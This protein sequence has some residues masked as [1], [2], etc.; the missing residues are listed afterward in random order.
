MKK[1]FLS[2]CLLL[3]GL[4]S[5]ACKCGNIQLTPESY[6]S[7]DIIFAG[8]LDTVINREFPGRQ[9]LVFYMDN[10]YKGDSLPKITFINTSTASCRGYYNKKAHYLVY[11]RYNK[12]LQAYATTTCQSLFTEPK[13]AYDTKESRADTT[14]GY[15]AG[16]YIELDFLEK[17]KQV[18][19][20]AFT[21]QYPGG[22]TYL[23]GTV[24]GSKPT[25]TWTYYDQGG[26]VLKSVSYYKRKSKKN[27]S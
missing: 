19:Y 22:R 20:G 3:A 9:E 26:A 12:E 1:H 14:L 13:A 17:M 25:E 8:H 6:S 2:F 10:V 27:P 24:Y 21:V 23:S 18:K 15:E 4:S 5:F 16:K 11:L 7:F